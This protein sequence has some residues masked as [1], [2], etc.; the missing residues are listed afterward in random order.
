MQA[1]LMPR[2][3]SAE[4][5]RYRNSDIHFKKMGQRRTTA[6]APALAVA[7][8]YTP[9][10]FLLPRPHSRT[11]AAHDAA[12]VALEVS[13]L[14]LLPGENVRVGDPSCG[15]SGPTGGAIVV[16]GVGLALLP[17]PPCARMRDQSGKQ[18][19]V[20]RNYRDRC[21]LPPLWLL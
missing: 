3:V 14:G 1:G 5:M 17:I 20:V 7:Q 9:H 10:T 15:A 6:P 11:N 4:P 18:W 19:E 12:Y 16:L 8:I 21:L 13:L 2:P